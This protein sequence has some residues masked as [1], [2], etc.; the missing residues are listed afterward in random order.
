MIVYPQGVELFPQ[1]T[2]IADEDQRG[3]ED[4]PQMP[5]IVYADDKGTGSF[6]QIPADSR[7]R[8]GREWKISRRCR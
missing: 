1:I 3:V 8:S 4:F 2:L 6:P 7:R 5:L